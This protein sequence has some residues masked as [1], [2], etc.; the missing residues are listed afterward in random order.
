MPLRSL[1]PG[2]AR[3][4]ERRAEADEAEAQAG[5]WVSMPA[6]WRPKRSGMKRHPGWHDR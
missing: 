6:T 1:L 5:E 3:E 4:I 2:L